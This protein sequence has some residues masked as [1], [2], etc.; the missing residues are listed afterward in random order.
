MDTSSEDYANTTSQSKMITFKVDHVWKI[1]NFKSFLSQKTEK[2]SPKFF[3][4]DHDIMFCF[5]IH[6]SKNDNASVNI[7]DLYLF[8]FPGK[9]IRG[10]I[11]ITFELGFLKNDGSFVKQGKYFIHSNKQ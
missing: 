9:T 2:F 3:V 8:C 1:D 6:H 5:R 11:P 10:G 4:A 7:I